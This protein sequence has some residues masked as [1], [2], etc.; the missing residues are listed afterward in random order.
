MY[1]YYI[2]V[3][4]R[5]LTIKEEAYQAL[6][7]EKKEG[8][9][10]TDVIL[11]LTSKKGSAHRLLEMMETGEFHSPEL[12]DK[13]EQASKEFRKNFKLRDVEL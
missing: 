7:S 1:V 9:S 3:P 4:T 8:E 6:K 5:T 11:R 2:A 10:F 12:A 13:V